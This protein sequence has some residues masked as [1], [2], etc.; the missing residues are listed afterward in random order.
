MITQEDIQQA[1]EA[2][3]AIPG[4]AGNGHTLCEWK[5]MIH[6]NDRAVSNWV[7]CGLADGTIR[8]VVTQRCDLV[9]RMQKTTLFEY[10]GGSNGQVAVSEAAEVKA[11]PSDKRQAVPR[12][13]AAARR[14]MGHR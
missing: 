5:D 6:R 1:L 12:R 13:K 8:R 4:Y 10:V 9:G 7:R 2:A 14:R 11:K 3:G